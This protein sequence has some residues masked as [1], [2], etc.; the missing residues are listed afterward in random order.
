[1]TFI[2]EEALSHQSPDNNLSLV[3]SDI[4]DVFMNVSLTHLPQSLMLYAS[5]SSTGGPS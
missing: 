3:R 4:L 5:S 2:A 1:M